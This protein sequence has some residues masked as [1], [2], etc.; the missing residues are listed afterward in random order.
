MFFLYYSTSSTSIDINADFY[1]TGETKHKKIKKQ[2]ATVAPVIFLF[3]FF[4]LFCFGSFFCFF[5][6]QKLRNSDYLYKTRVGKNELTV[7]SI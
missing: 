7:Y 5:L 1:N 3:F 6:S 2:T 4:S